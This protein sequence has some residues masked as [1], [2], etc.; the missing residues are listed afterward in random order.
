MAPPNPTSS[1]HL[2]RAAPED[3]SSVLRSPRFLGQLTTECVQ[4]NRDTNF[5][6]TK[7][8]HGVVGN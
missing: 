6:N 4:E 1:P 2:L 3:Q 7:E 8:D 5:R